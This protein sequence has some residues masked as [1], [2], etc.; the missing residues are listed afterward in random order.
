M[1]E[2]E[3]SGEM[4]SEES[5]GVGGVVDKKRRIDTFFRTVAAVG[6][7][8]LHLKSDAVPRV[9]VGG[10]LRVLKTAALSPQEVSDIVEEMLNP[11]QQHDF[12]THGT[13]DL[14]Y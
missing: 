5:H 12:H 7:S 6:G 10:E 8:D 11:E 1:S 9:R 3:S 2:A 4:P 14:A 13:L